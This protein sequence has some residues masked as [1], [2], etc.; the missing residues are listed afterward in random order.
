MQE[1]APAAQ[2]AAAPAPHA[3]RSAPD[4]RVLEAFHKVLAAAG[5]VIYQKEI[6]AQLL[7]MIKS[8]ED[9]VA[10]A[11]QA[12]LTVLDQ[13]KLQMKGVQPEF[14]YT[15][16]PIV[17]SLLLEM[18]DAAK[19]VKLDQALVGKVVQ[20]V[21]AQLK[22]GAQRGAPPAPAQAPAQPQPQPQPP[23]AM[24]PGMEA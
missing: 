6:S 23:G 18:A 17:A 19:L 13:I 3:K 12:V 10:G 9:P 5:K 8:G 4:P 14:V 2:P 15:V 7:R 22:G 16:V 20:A 24:A 11:A 1:G 21:V